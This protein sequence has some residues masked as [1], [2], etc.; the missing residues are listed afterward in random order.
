MPLLHGLPLFFSILACMHGFK[1]SLHKFWHDFSADPSMSRFEV[2]DRTGP[3]N[4]RGLQICIAQKYISRFI[5]L[6]L[7]Q[8][9]HAAQAQRVR[10]VLFAV[11]DDRSISSK[12]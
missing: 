3:P 10:I 8:F 2:L 9:S 12:S 5:R 1:L 6:L 7:G 11:L 4:L